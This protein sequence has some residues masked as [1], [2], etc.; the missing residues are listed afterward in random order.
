MRLLVGP[1]YGSVASFNHQDQT[2]L[3]IHVFISFVVEE[4]LDYHA[5]RPVHH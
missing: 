1:R 5:D 2:V 3:D 4:V